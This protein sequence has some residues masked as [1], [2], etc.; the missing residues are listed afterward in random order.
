MLAQLHHDP[1]TAHFV[2]DRTGCAGA[3][4][5]VENQIAGFGQKLYEEL[6]ELNREA[7]WVGRLGKAKV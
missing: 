4:K 3:T 6:G 5:G 7:G 2:G 1:A